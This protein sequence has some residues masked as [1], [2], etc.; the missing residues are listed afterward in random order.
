MKWQR[1]FILIHIK[2]IRIIYYI[3]FQY[4]GASIVIA[5]ENHLKQNNELVR[6]QTKLNLARAKLQQAWDACGE[7]DAAVLRAGNEFDSLLNEYQSR[8]S[9]VG[10]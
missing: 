2:S 3:K 8:L 10:N 5:L 6:L 9:K 7:T 1:N 4:Q